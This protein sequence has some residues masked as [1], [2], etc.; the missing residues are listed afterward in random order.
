[1]VVPLSLKTYEDCLSISKVLHED[2]N[3]ELIL[4]IHGNTYI[5]RKDAKQTE[6]FVKNTILM[7]NLLQ[8]HTDLS[9]EDCP[10]DLDL[11]L[12]PATT[13]CGHTFNYSAIKNAVKAN[14]KCPM[15]RTLEPKFIENKA[16]RQ[17][18]VILYNNRKSEELEK[19]EREKVA[20]ILQSEELEIN[21]LKSKLPEAETVKQQLILTKPKLSTLTLEQVTAKNKEYNARKSTF[22][23]MK[24]YVD[25]VSILIYVLVLCAGGI[26]LTFAPLIAVPILLGVVLCMA[27]ESTGKKF[28]AP[29]TIPKHFI[30]KK[31]EHCNAK[32]E[33]NKKLSATAK[34][35]KRL[36]IKE[37]NLARIKNDFPVKQKA[38][39]EKH[40]A[41]ASVNPEVTARPKHF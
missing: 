4:D 16:L 37:Q 24:K 15:C 20:Q 35:Q 14:H 7:N 40:V 21:E 25:T 3:K 19:D 6:R 41:Q 13:S 26:A 9:I 32:I 34:M 1:M 33:R 23:S 27:L 18:N 30:D 29:T 10:I 12:T 36:D 28:I 17:L 22:F 39:I 31:I 38:L 8:I 2:P 11:M 5:A